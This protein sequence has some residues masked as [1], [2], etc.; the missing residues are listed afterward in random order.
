MSDITTALRLDA[1]TTLQTTRTTAIYPALQP[2][3]TYPTQAPER[4]PLDYALAYHLLEGAAA[5]A[6]SCDAETLDWYR[7]GPSRNWSYLTTA[8]RLGPRVV[9]A[10]T[11]EQMI[12]TPLSETPYYVIGPRTSVAPDDLAALASSAFTHTADAGLGSLISAHAAVVC[13]TGHR[14]PYQVLRNFSITRLP[15]T[16]FT[17]HIGDS[18]VLGRELVHEA[19]HNWLNDALTALQITIPDEQV[20]FSPWRDTERPAFGFLHAC[21]AFPLSMVYAA[22]ILPS[23]AGTTRTVLADHL[24]QQRAHLTRAEHDFT[25]ALGLVPN[26][27]LRHRLETVYQHARAL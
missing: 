19:A 27:T 1:I 18:R 15:A 9:L 21:F 6:R 13:L 24:S 22:R 2:D 17:D 11:P 26:E 25:Q 23:A 5:A 10:P 16:V 4:V 12:R 3:S 7:A 20:F 8:T 14:R